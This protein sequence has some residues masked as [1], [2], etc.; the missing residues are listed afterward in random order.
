MF[1]L[2]ITSALAILTLQVFSQ[3]N[4]INSKDFLNTS[5]NTCLNTCIPNTTKNLEI[6]KKDSI[7]IKYTTDKWIYINVNSKWIKNNFQ[8]GKLNSFYYEFSNPQALTDSA[9]VRHKINLVHQGNNLDTSYTGK[10]VIIGI[11]DQGIDFNHPD[12]KFSNGKTR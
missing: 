10:G 9:I 8:K 11:V 4:P 6:L 3:N 5:I 12:F 7:K 2:V 1:K